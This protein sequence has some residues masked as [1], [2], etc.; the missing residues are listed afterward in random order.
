M[1]CGGGGKLQS[2]VFVALGKSKTHTF[3]ELIEMMMLFSQIISSFN[4]WMGPKG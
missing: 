1:S 2:S 4:L 3:E